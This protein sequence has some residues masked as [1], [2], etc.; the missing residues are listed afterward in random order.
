MPRLVLAASIL[1]SAL[2]GACA[3]PAPEPDAE[4]DVTV[5]G[6]DT[7]CSLDKSVLDYEENYTYEVRWP[8]KDD[9]DV[10]TTEIRIT[11]EPFATGQTSGC[12]IEYASPTWL[13]ERD[14]GFIKWSLVGVA[15]QQQG[16]GGCDIKDKFDWYGTET[17]TVTESKDPEIPEGCTYTM[18]VEGNYLGGGG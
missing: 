7:T 12:S 5:R 9:G 14:Q 3:V 15:D 10:T 16:A 18:T 1:G 2:F 13:D 8:N 11:G 6:D 17:I 4:W